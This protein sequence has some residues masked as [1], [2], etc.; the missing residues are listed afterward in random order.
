MKKRRIR[1]RYL[2]ILVFFNLSRFS[3]G[4]GIG[5]SSYPLKTKQRLVSIEMVGLLSS[6]GA[7]IST[8]YIH[9]L[10][11]NLL[12]DAGLGLNGERMLGRIFAG[13]DITLWPDYRQQPKVSLKMMFENNQ[14]FVNKRYLL[15]AAPTF[16]KSMSFWGKEG[17]PFIAF[18]FGINLEAGTG[19]QYESFMS[20]HLGI[21]GSLPIQ[22]FHKIVLNLEGMIDLKNTTSGMFIGISHPLE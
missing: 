1:V 11:E 8:R 2:I 12:L 5:Y 13:L 4:Y 14:K 16:S 21:T 20:I 22:K 17:H 9:K 18:P 7:G 3:L 15:S 19:N 10:N 6:Q